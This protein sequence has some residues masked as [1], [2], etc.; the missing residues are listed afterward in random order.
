MQPLTLSRRDALK[1]FS[2][3]LLAVSTLHASAA[4]QRSDRKMTINLMP[5][6]IGLRA[7]QREA[8]ELAHAH[9]FESVEA[10][11]GELARMSDDEIKELIATMRG[12]H[13]VFGAAGLT[14]DFRGD[15]SKFQEGLKDLPKIADALKRAG[16]DR[17]GTWIMPGHNLL[18]HLQNLKQHGRRLRA[19]ADVLGERGIR[20]GL[21]YVG[22]KTLR[23][24]FH[25][26]FVHTMAETKELIAEIGAKNVGFILDSWHWWNANE[27][28]QDILTLEAEQIVACDLNDAPA[29]V[30]KEK[31]ID[32]QR[33][34]P[35]ATGVI[36]AASFLNALQ[37]LGYDGPVRA[38]PFNKAL[39]D[40]ENEEACAR[41][42]DA[43]QR[44]FALVK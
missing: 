3:S 5:G 23:D 10:M 38:E 44:A 39:N 16:V 13:V 30:P 27:T 36:P 18:T 35:L 25:Y 4:E 26:E 15:D 11:G 41:T 21:E 8:I 14:V 37:K 12:K 42:F 22:T 40:L 7:N 33:E 9:G 1:C 19:I 24:R 17:V 32:G 28:D 34:L 2:G 31:Q 43:M 29:G 6:M 20:L